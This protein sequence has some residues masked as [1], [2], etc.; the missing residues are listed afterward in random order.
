MLQP[1]REERRDVYGLTSKRRE[2]RKVSV[3]CKA[4]ISTWMVVKRGLGFP[5]SV[6]DGDQD[7]R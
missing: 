2:P 1:S 7:Q 6:F 4:V 5:S 3:Q